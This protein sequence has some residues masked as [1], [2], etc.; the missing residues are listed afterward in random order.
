MKTEVKVEVG[1][2]SSTL[3]FKEENREKVKGKEGSIKGVVI[4]SSAGYYHVRVGDKIYVCSLRGRIKRENLDDR[5]RPIYANPVAVGDEVMVSL[6]DDR[7]GVIEEILPRR[8]KFSRRLPGRQ[9]LEQIIVA[10][11][12]QVVVILSA[13]MPEL[14]LRFLDRFLILAEAGELDAVVCVNKMDLVTDEERRAIELEMMVYE[15]LGYRLCYTSAVTGE[16]IEELKRILKDRFSVFVG[17]SG[18]GKSSL[19]NVIQPGLSLKIREVN[20]KTGRGRH[21]TSSVQMVE[22]YFGGYVADTPGVREVK[23]WGVD[24]DNLDLYFPEMRRFI[25]GCRYKDC[26]HIH[27]P[28]CAVKEAVMRGE[29]S[30]KRYESYL[31][32]K[33][34]YEKGAIPPD[35]PS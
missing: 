21:T 31:R 6:L 17:A 34:Y 5:G 7:G 12:D 2:K 14:N 33:G 22:L 29:I 28:K 24:R 25:G 4:R 13:K 30:P 10:N 23:L 18:V 11:A 20:P 3:T 9:P 19:L 1:K 8:T 26:M 27:E 15:D 35:R 32:L 16:G